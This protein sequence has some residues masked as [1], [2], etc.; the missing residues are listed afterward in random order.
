MKK[1]LSAILLSYLLF[2]TC[3]SQQYTIKFGTVAPDGSTWMN[4]MREYDAAIRK[5]SGGRAGFKFFAG[6]VQG[7]EKAVLRKIRFGQLSSAGFSGVGMGEI[8]PLVRILDTPFLV[9]NYA[10]MDYIYQ[11]FSNDFE[12]AF[13]D[14]GYILLGWAEVGFV[15]VFTNTIVQKP[16]DLKS[17][18]MW[19]WEGD[20]IAEV[21]FSELGITPIPLP[22]ENVLTSLQTGLVDAFY[23][24]PY[25]A[26]TLQWY[27]KVKY[28]IDAPLADAAGSVLISKKYYDTMP[29]DLQEILVRNGRLYMAKLTK[30]SRKDNQDAIEQFKKRG[31][32]ILKVD[33]KDLPKYIDMGARVRKKLVGRTMFTDEFVQRVEKELDEFRKHPA[34]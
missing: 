9:R 17:V 10:E 5:E 31:V 11:K 26:V 15:H 19:A 8:A 28:M 18:K 30:L 1:I 32:Q 12:K 3:L 24:S 33:P 16:E 6:G 29:K 2:S 7:D 25:A 13:E 22:L 4:V 23:T 34:K 14:G 27:T 20:P 21:A